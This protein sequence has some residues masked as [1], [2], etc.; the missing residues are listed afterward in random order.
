MSKPYE[1]IAELIREGNKLEA[2]K[3]LRESTGIG[4][5]EAKDEIDRLEAELAGEEVPARER[6]EMPEEAYVEV[7]ALALQGKKIEAIKRLRDQSGMGLK[8]AKEYVDAL[9]GSRQAGCAKSVA[10]VVFIAIIL[11]GAVIFATMAV[12]F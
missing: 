12:L 7:Q 11:V 1:R 3:L 9:G 5:K 8:E 10:M 6:T 2:I 4:L